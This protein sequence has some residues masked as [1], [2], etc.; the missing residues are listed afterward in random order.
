MFCSIILYRKLL[1]ERYQ[2][3]QTNQNGNLKISLNNFTLL[4]DITICSK[5]K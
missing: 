1:T 5:N 4:V 3:D 2:T